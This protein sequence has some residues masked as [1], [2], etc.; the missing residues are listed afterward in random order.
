LYNLVAAKSS[1]G[2]K[3]SR[4]RVDG[5]IYGV[6]RGPTVDRDG[7]DPV[8]GGENDSARFVAAGFGSRT[9]L[10]PCSGVAME[11]GAGVEPDAFARRM[12]V[13]LLVGWCD[14]YHPPLKQ[15]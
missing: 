13:S 12:I 11:D 7:S 4:S 6:E 2:S 3:I 1:I 14:F 9:R 5:W 15:G 8:A 10:F